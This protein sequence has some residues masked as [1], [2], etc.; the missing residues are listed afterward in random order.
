MWCS[1]CWCP[2]CSWEYPDS[3]ITP[4]KLITSQARW[5]TTTSAGKYQL[6]T[7]M[8]T[9]STA[10]TP[11]V[12]SYSSGPKL[13][14]QFYRPSVKKLFNIVIRGLP[15]DIDEDTRKVLAEIEQS[16]KTCLEVKRRP[17]RLSVAIPENDIV[18]NR[19]L[20]IDVFFL[21]GKPVLSTGDKYKNFIASALLKND[22]AQEI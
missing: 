10:G 18:S 19:E 12:M 15:K 21:G 9:F 3:I 14:M 5:C 20:L 2:L 17:Y 22:S 13:H 11:I 8:G 7:C 6:H 1:W 4:C 16:W